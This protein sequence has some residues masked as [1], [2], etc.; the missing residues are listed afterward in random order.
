LAYSDELIKETERR[1]KEID[2]YRLDGFSED[3]TA[4]I[5]GLLLF[6]ADFAS[7]LIARLPERFR[8]VSKFNDKQWVLQVQSG[9]GLSIGGD[10]KPPSEFRLL[11]K[12]F[13]LSFDLFR[14]EPWL[15]PLMNNWVAENT[16]LI[17]SIPQQYLGNIEGMVRRA[18]QSGLSSKEL[19]KQIADTGLVTKNRAKLIA[20]DQIAKA[21][22]AIT[23]YRQRD[24]GIDSYIWQTAEDSRVRP[25]HAAMNGKVI[26]WDQP[27]S[28]GHAGTPVR[29]RCRAKP[30][31][32]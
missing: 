24:L 31:F 32:K 5:A 13:G 17:K 20:Q 27:P 10:G 19:A 30:V 21:D 29:C 18:V 15:N 9:T 16:R 1:I 7:P 4:I 6:A 12:Q 25:E 26:R 14:S 2:K 23:E 28:I 8:Q 22:A 11:Q 3:L